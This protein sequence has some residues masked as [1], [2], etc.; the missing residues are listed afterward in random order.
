MGK[1]WASCCGMC[2]AVDRGRS[3]QVES[4]ASRRRMLIEILNYGGFIS[5]DRW[6]PSCELPS[7]ASLPDELNAFYARLE[8][9]NTEACMRA[10][11]VP[12]D[13]SKTL[14]FTRLQGLTDYQDAYSELAL[15][16]WKVS[17]LTFSTSL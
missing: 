1:A 15:S 16:S 10:P 9:I 4:M 3:S 12:A 11:A 6:K 2:G 17:S 14:T 5:G 7:D 13:V 8:A